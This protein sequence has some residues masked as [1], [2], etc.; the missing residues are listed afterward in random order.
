MP[1]TE[2]EPPSPPDIL[3][4]DVLLLAPRND[5]RFTSKRLADRAHAERLLAAVRD[6]GEAA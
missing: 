1:E 6:K 5:A 3:A 2:T 4:P